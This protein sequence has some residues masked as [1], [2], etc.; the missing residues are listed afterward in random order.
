MYDVC[1]GF[2]LCEVNFSVD[3]GALGELPGLCGY[4]AFVDEGLEYLFDDN[5]IAVASEFDGV[6]AGVGVRCFVEKGGDGVNGVIVI[7]MEYAI[8]NGVALCLL[9]CVF[10]FEALVC[11]GYCIVPAESYDG[12]SGSAGRCGKS[13]DGVLGIIHG[14]VVMF[15]KRVWCAV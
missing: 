8:V 12:K 5:H 15:R 3:E 9:E 7:V 11:D 10:S 2:D 4:C 1:N 6:F 13:A 14:C